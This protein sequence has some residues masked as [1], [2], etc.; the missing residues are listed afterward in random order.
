MSPPEKD[1]NP[2]SY[3]ESISQQSTTPSIPG[4]SITR[5]QNLLDQLT[6]V[7]A[8]NIR[9]VIE[10]HILPRVEEQA[11]YGI[12]RSI[13]ALLPSD[14]P[15]PAAEEKSEFSFDTGG[16]EKKV[17]VIGFSSDE[18]PKI[19]RL[20]GQMNKTEFWRVKAVIEDLERRLRETLSASP[21]LRRPTSPVSSEIPPQREQSKKGLG[22]FVKMAN[23]LGQELRSNSNSK[24]GVRQVEE[25]AQVLVKVRLEEICLRTVSEFGLYDTMSKQCVIIRVDARC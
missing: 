24:V 22:F 7:R 13:I 12:S 8:Q 9:S 15:L 20:E 16:D 11:A 17:E 2:P 23:A 5:G 4:P 25:V 18:E 3:S 19:V 14:I 21:V 6:L 1:N 10:D